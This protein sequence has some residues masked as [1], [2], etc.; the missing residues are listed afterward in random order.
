MFRVDDTPS[1]GE[2]RMHPV[3]YAIQYV[4]VGVLRGL[5]YF[6]VSRDFDKSFRAS[7]LGSVY[8]TLEDIMRT[9]NPQRGRFLLG[10][11][12]YAVP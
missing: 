5:D 9:H 3:Y 11:Q 7:I 8:K 4:H 12:L 10:S 6:D 1:S 2:K